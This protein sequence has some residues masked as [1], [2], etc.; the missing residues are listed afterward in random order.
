VNNKL[1]RAVAA[2]TLDIV[3]DLVTVEGVEIVQTGIEYPLAS[4]PHTFT[5]EDL[6]DAVAAQDDPA[7]KAPRLRLGHGGLRDPDWDGEPAIGVVSNMRLEQMGHK[8]VGDYENIPRWLATALPGAYPGRSIDGEI[9]VVTNTGHTWGLVITGMALLG[10]RW[11]GVS[12]LEDIKALFS[13]DGPDNVKVYTTEE[14]DDVTVAAAGRVQARL[15]VD[16][17]RRQFYSSLEG[18]DSWNM[19]IRGQYYDPDELIV[20]D[21]SSGDLFRVPYTINGQEVEFGDRVA[22]LEEF[23]DK[24]KQPEKATALRAVFSAINTYRQPVVLYASR[25][26]SRK[27]IEVTGSTV[28]TPDPKALRALVGLGEDAT[29]E[30]LNTA[31]EAAGI[32]FKPGSEGGNTAPGAESPGTTD[33]AS[34]ASGS[35]VPDVTGPSGNN[36]NDPAVAAPTQSPVAGVR[37]M[38]EETYQRL[39]AG[40]TAGQ[41]ALARFENTDRDTAIS[42]A[43]KAGKI[44]KSRQEHWVEAWK[45][46]PEGTKT[47]LTAAADKGG[48]APGLIPVTETGGVPADGGV[49]DEQDAG[50]PAEW[51]PEVAARKAREQ[52]LAAAQGQ[53]LLHPNAY[54]MRR[55]M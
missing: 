52:A 20:E 32:I 47:L 5:V 43:I 40:A 19:W 39:M 21:E 11:P 2:P 44:P 34:S 12:T 55:G 26:E 50:Y 53:G 22:V 10:I 54:L 7:I 6:A 24:P 48:L 4:G 3:A 15:D 23:I 49:E 1:L 46:D 41:T 28:T 33:S 29:D 31:L 51:L 27:D 30:A 9:G 16:V 45:R 25:D 36:K 18:S 42:A 35:P 8:I 38:D 17:V 13:K 14:V 37:T